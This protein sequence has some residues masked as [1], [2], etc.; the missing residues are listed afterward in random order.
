MTKQ[1][2]ETEIAELAHKVAAHIQIKMPAVE[3]LQVELS[4][5]RQ[6]PLLFTNTYSQLW[7]DKLYIAYSDIDDPNVHYVYLTDKHIDEEYRSYNASRRER[8]K[9]VCLPEY[10][11]EI[12]RK[13]LKE[14]RESEKNFVIY[15]IG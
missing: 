15:E 3:E 6:M 4:K 12:F 8:N 1:L 7:V 10:L 5:R 13:A 2:K 11:N 9:D 14:M